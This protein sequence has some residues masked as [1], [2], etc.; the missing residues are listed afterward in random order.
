MKIQKLM[1]FK[2]DDDEEEIV[3]VTADK[4]HLNIHNMNNYGQELV[5]NV[6]LAGEYLQVNGTKCFFGGWQ[7]N[8]RLK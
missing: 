7:A 4:G 2:A 1:G 5:T 8:G 3:K 6:K